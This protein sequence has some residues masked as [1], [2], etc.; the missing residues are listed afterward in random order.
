MQCDRLKKLAR[1]WSDQI[2]E[3]ALAPARMVEFAIRH[4]KS[5]PVCQADPTVSIE[6]AKVRKMLVPFISAWDPQK[7]ARFEDILA[8]Y[9][10]AG[11]EEELEPE[12]K[13]PAEEEIEGATEEEEI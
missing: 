3:D 8:I 12:E 9:A 4:I 13:A 11:Y 7:A 1:D 2:I 5:C 10:Y 6:Q